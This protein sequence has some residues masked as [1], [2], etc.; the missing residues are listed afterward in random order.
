MAYREGNRWT[1]Q[2]YKA[3]LSGKRKQIKKRGFLTKRDAL[4]YERQQKLK[5]SGVMDMKLKVFVEKYFEDKANDLK[6]R[7]IRNKKYLMEQHIIPYFGEMK[8]TEIAPADILE[9]QNEMYKKGFSE[10]YLRMIQ[11]QLTALFTHA[12]RIYDMDVNPIKKVKRMGKSDSRNIDF[13]TLDEYKA[14]ISTVDPEDKYYILFE[15]LF[16]TGCRI[17]EALALTIA[18]V[19]FS[20]NQINIDKTYYRVEGRDLITEPKTEQ[21]IRKIEIPQFLADEIKGYVD[22]LYQYPAEER[23]FP[24]VQEAVQHK[25]KRNLEK[26]G[27]KQ[28]RVHDLRHSHV[29][30]LIDRGVEPLIIKERLGHKDIRITLNTYG[31][32][33]P[34]QQKKIADLLDF[35]MKKNSDDG[36]HQSSEDTAD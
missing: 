12:T 28:I 4:D 25:M 6:E 10:S 2:Y 17:G 11:N 5:K 1:A 30:Y 33:Y 15:I 24:V 19:N 3:D 23:L 32:L 31:H 27:V 21:S 13:W 18:D 29:A 36:N 7:T 35:E 9:W 22:R 20:K 26:A 14:F 34:S 16:W 8:M